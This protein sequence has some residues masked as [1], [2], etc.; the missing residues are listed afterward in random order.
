M[1]FRPISDYTEVRISIPI[2]SVFYISEIKPYDKSKLNSSRFYSSHSPLGTDN[3]RF[4]FTTLAD[5][6]VTWPAGAEL[7]IQYAS[8]ERINIFH[9][10]KW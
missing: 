1:L 6:Y 2:R 8:L 4:R 5:S 9:S 10:G 3:K 7:R